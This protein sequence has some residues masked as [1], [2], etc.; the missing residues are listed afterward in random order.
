MATLSAKARNKLSDRDFAIPERRAYPI[1]DI[2]HARD[3]LARVSAYGTPE[4][5]K[6]VH[7]AVR[8]RYPALWK[9]HEEYRGNRVI[10]RKFKDPEGKEYRQAVVRHRGRVT[11]RV[12]EK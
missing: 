2:A 11:E 8:R 1:Q 5:K 12:K 3:A 6:R 10:L 7:E 9:R 4:E